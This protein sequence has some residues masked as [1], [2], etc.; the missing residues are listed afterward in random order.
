MATE[1][2]EATEKRR[3][4]QAGAWLRALREE[5]G[6]TQE[7]LAQAAGTQQQTIYRLEKGEV[8]RASLEDMAGIAKVMGLDLNQMGA[9]RGV[10]KLSSPGAEESPSSLATTAGLLRRR[11]ALLPPEDQEL[12]AEIV[13]TVI[14][15]LLHRRKMPGETAL[16]STLPAWLQPKF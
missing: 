1:D 9:L 6:L 3:V 14:S 8:Q 4:Q 5:R 7:A 10:W 12:L 16:P 13:V 2:E 11:G 15:G